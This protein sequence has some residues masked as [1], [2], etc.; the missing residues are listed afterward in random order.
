[1]RL[2]GERETLGLFLTGHPIDR[3]EA[4]LPR[5]VGARIADLISE[6][7][8]PGGSEFARF[9][10]KPTA[11]AGLIHEIRRRGTRVSLD[12]CTARAYALLQGV[13]VQL[14]RSEGGVRL[15]SLR[16]PPTHEEVTQEESS[17]RR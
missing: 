12:R 10:S 11:A 7:P 9:S 15:G 4:D 16:G 6:R 3:F 5:F 1:M 17:G 13:G 14:R 2:A 8:L